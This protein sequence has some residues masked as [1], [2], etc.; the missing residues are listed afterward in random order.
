MP[1]G[2]VVAH[3]AAA[4]AFQPGNHGTTF[5]GNPL[6]CSAGIAV[7]ETM[8][9]ENL[10]ARAKKLGDKLVTDFKRALADN[11]K[12]VDVRGKGL[13]I[14]LELNAPC[15]DLVEKG[16]AKG[17]LINVTSVNTIRLLPTFIMTDAE[18]EELVTKVVE[19][20]TEF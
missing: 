16:R 8:L 6:A 9:S 14:G 11:K 5:G 3:G 1:I 4:E 7:I 13:M 15:S 2:A 10:I 18:V 19:L 12:V 17:I 20:V